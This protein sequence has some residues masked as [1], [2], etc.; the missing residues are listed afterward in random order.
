MTNW[1]GIAGRFFGSLERRLIGAMALIIALTLLLQF[2]SQ[3]EAF[4]LQRE[5]D[6]LVRASALAENADQFAEAVGKL[7]TATNRGL[8]ASDITTT[9]DTLTDAAIAIGDRLAKLRDS[10][11]V[12]Y[13]L[14]ATA[15]LFANLDQH[16]AAILQVQATRGDKS[17]LIAQVEAKNAAMEALAV[18][19]VEQAHAHRQAAQGRL[20]SSIERWQ[21]LVLGTGGVTILVVLIVLFDLM[22]NILPAVRRM[23]RSLQRLA[24]GD[25]DIE[26]GAFRLQELQALSGPLETFRRNAKAVKNLAFTDAATGM[27]NR[28]AF[29]EAAEKLLTDSSDGRFAFMLID[30]DRFKH[31]NDDYGHATGDELVR[32]IGARMKSFLGDRSLVARVGG[33]EFAVALPLTAQVTGIA[34][35]SALVEAMRE[36]FSLGEYS[37]ASTVSL[38]VAEVQLPTG[39][40]VD[41]ILRNADLAL[42]AS[43]KNGR[44]CATAFA[45]HMAE[46]RSVDRA[47]EKDLES[48]FDAGQL[49]M[50]YQPI[51]SIDEDCREVEA[52]V[53]W[54]HPELGE[55]PPST[56]IPA[57]ERSGLMVRLGEW[58][59]RRALQDFAQWPDIHMSLNLSPL[60]LQHDGFST[61]LL[62]CCRENGI[63]PQRLFLEVTESLSIERNT[64]ALLTLNLLR[65]LGFRIALDDFGTGYSSLSMV[66]SFKFD[67]MKLDRSLVM[68]LGQDPASLAVL[69]AAVTMAR[70]VGAEVV[71]EGISEDHLV[72]PTRSAGCTHLQGY[73]YSHPIEAGHVWNYIAK[74]QG[75]SARAA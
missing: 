58:I 26:I 1:N 44:N 39:S 8:V 5:S 14:P 7:R 33:D 28:R 50:V 16:V 21:F 37:V 72:G 36:P 25:L 52:L 43:K 38:G 60:Q 13:D 63:A 34:K 57:A 54:K 3:R 32:I 30:I 20:V 69:E 18:K 6:S 15:Q 12:L 17:A 73:F 53:R 23:H 24:D 59:I 41:A 46:E 48:A 27:P 62:D 45:A 40:D 49:R 67:R 47:L 61:F 70:H 75:K 65:N 31:I 29:Q 9:S 64:R 42:Y 10:G 74:V 71:A 66:K 68:D 56:F 11:T 51:H 2:V 55:V 4:G 35:G 22:R 19:I